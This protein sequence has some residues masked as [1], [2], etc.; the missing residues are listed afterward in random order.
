M[1]SHIALAVGE[2][3]KNRDTSELNDFEALTPQMITTNPTTSSAAD[4]PL[5]TMPFDSSLERFAATEKPQHDQDHG[6]NQQE[7]NQPAH[8]VR[9]DEPQ[10][11]EDDQDNDDGVQ[12]RVSFF[13]FSRGG[14]GHPPAVKMI[15]AIRT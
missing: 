1:R 14:F 10:Q 5:F 8:G 15:Q 7:V 2:P 3:V 13:W 4:M 12:H 6:D 11:P 9:G